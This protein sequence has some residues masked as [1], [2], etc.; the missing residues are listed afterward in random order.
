ML[1]VEVRRTGRVVRVFI[2]GMMKW[3]SGGRYGMIAAEL[4][5]IDTP[6]HPQALDLFLQAFR[7]HPMGGRSCSF[8]HYL[9]TPGT[10]P[11]WGV[12]GFAF[13]AN[14]YIF[15]RLGHKIF[16]PKSAGFFPNQNDPGDLVESL[17]I[18]YEL[19]F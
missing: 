12:W 8:L 10:N 3:P 19:L 14:Q 15:F 16:L 5:T 4:L 7:A 2:S 13:S 6:L 11:L 18:L 17:T 9:I 1:L